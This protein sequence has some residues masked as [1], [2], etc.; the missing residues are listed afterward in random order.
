MGACMHARMHAQVEE[1]QV[2]ATV[3]ILR[4]LKERYEVHHGVRILDSALVEAAHLAS[5][6][7]S[8]RFLP[9]KAID[10]V[11]EAAARLKN[12]VSSKP[13]QLDQLDRLLLQLEMERISI[14]G[15]AKTRALDEQAKLRLRAV[16]SHIE[17]LQAEQV[18]KLRPPPAGAA[19]AAA[20]WCDGWEDMVDGGEGSRL[21][22]CLHAC[23]ALCGCSACMHA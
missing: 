8:D 20:A 11:D 10:L 14:L 1:P 5:R 9:D 3:S 17:R 13:I 18:S 6:Y 12:Q 19:A 21:F 23:S 7:I 16:E 22:A 15:D 2:E 4:G